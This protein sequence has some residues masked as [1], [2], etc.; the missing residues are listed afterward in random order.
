LNDEDLSFSIEREPDSPG[1]RFI[2]DRIFE[3]NEAIVGA[4]AHQP[5]HLT[6]HN[7]GGQIIAGLIGGTYWR[8][9]HIDFLWVANAYRRRGIGSKLVLA[10][11][12]EAVQRGCNHCHTETH[13]FQAPEFYRRAGYMQYT[14][15]QDLPEG[16][17][18]YFFHKV[19]GWSDGRQT[20]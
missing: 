17:T 5:L 18:K 3:H 4:D 12:E 8:W 7:R 1:A 19:L 20:P 14:Q 9:L 6:V 15:L 11:E 10:A 16:H 13:D 2:R